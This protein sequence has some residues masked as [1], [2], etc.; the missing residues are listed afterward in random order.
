[1]KELF[2]EYTIQEGVALNRVK[3]DLQRQTYKSKEAGCPWRAHGSQLLDKLTFKLF[4]LGS[5]L[6]AI[7]QA[8]LVLQINWMEVDAHKLKFGNR[9]TPSITMDAVKEAKYLLDRLCDRRI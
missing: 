7:G 5:V 9:N 3:N 6:S 1:M 2:R 4:A 8:Q